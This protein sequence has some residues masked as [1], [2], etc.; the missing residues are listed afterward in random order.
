MLEADEPRVRV[1]SRH[2]NAEPAV[3]ARSHGGLLGKPVHKHAFQ[4]KVHPW[5]SLLRQQAES[6][7]NHLPALAWMLY[8]SS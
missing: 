7:G 6:G 2:P 4:S 8:V 5:R 1:A 3:D